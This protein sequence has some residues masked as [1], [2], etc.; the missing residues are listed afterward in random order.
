VIEDSLSFG[1][2]KLMKA[3][4]STIAPVL[5][6]LGL[7]PGQE[8]LLSQLWRHDA[9]TQAELVERL[10]VEPPTVTKTVRRL[11]AAGFVRREAGG[12]RGRRVLLTDAGRA[13]QAPVEQAWH[14]ADRRLLDG[15]AARDEAA[16]RAA[17]DRL[18][19]HAISR[20]HND[21][22]AG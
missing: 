21:E 13:L 15:L 7:H 10:R 22:L 14:D 3:T 17:L 12:G 2:L 19:D 6:E 8:L 4:R 1:L 11:E 18:R 16:A 5:A 20:L 9:L